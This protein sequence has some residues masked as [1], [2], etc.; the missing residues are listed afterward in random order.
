MADGRSLTQ[1]LQLR[2]AFRDWPKALVA[3]LAWKRLPLPA[4]TMVLH[5]RG[6][7]R[8]AA[9]LRRDAGSL[10]TAFEVFAFGSYER[11][12]ALDDGA[13]VVDVGANLGA[14]VLWAA[15]RCAGLRGLAFEPDP[16]AHEFLMRN[17]ELN[18][19]DGVQAHRSAVGAEAGSA[20]LH[21][22][23]DGDGVSTLFPGAGEHDD[24][25][26]AALEVPVTAFDELIASLGEQRI[27]V[28]KLD[29]EG[30]EHRI[31]NASADRSWACIDRV[32]CEYHPVDGSAVASLEETLLRRGF[33]VLARE[34]FAPELGMLWFSR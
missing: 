15:E 17:L 21:R 2:T 24:L 25:L 14:F 26:V 31:V 33:R 5:T 7:T 20:L 11:V 4:T 30:A 18:A 29:C 34:E 9:P 6:G 32:A 12:G 13:F 3:G 16:V 8:V 19:I 22:S 1:V 23:G 28:L 27:A 10:Y